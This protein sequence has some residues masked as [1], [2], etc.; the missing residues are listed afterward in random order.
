MSELLEL[1]AEEL[2]IPTTEGDDEAATLLDAASNG[3]V[4]ATLELL[5]LGAE[6]PEDN[7]LLLDFVAA[8]P[9]AVLHQAFVRDPPLASSAVVAMGRSL[10]EAEWGRRDFDYANTPLG[11]FLTAAKVAI[12]L[13]DWDLLDDAS[14]ALFAGEAQWNRFA[15][16]REIFGWLPTLTGVAADRVS[17]ALRRHKECAQRFTSLVEGSRRSS[18]LDAKIDAVL[19]AI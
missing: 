3:D 9:S 16:Q 13:N 1:V 18:G 11:F 19:R 10:V 5:R 4:D 6:S 2:D 7:E 17:R 14:D 8:V 15:T 12:R